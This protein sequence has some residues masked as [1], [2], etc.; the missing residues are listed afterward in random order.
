M[1]YA[2]ALAGVTWQLVTDANVCLD[3]S[4]CRLDNHDLLLLKNIL[5]IYLYSYIAHTA[6]QCN[7]TNVTASKPADVVQHA[8]K[9][10]LDVSQR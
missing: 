7:A 8:Y 2:E 3:T 1:R 9:S 5:A 6:M 4:K 10:L